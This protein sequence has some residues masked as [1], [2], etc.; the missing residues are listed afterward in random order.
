MA[1]TQTAGV[2]CSVTDR[3]TSQADAPR[4][5]CRITHRRQRGKKIDRHG[6]RTRLPPPLRAAITAIG[7]E[8][9]ADTADAPMIMLA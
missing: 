4:G 9:Q 1:I 7:E 5:V 2:T 8:I 6:S 3:A